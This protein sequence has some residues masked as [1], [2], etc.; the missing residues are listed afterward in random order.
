MVLFLFLPSGLLFLKLESTLY[1]SPLVY[2]K[3][4]HHYISHTITRTLYSYQVAYDIY[5]CSGHLICTILIQAPV[6]PQ[7][8]IN[9]SMFNCGQWSPTILMLISVTPEQ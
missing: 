8:S 7:Q 4:M 2:K 6:T 5:K 3:K 9:A 1:S